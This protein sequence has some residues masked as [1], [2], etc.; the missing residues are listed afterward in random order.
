MT[1]NGFDIVPVD[2]ENSRQVGTVF[3]SVYG[4]DYPVKDVYRPD[5]LWR[6]VREGRLK[7]ALAFDTDG[8]PAGYVSLIKTAPNPRLWEAGSLVVDPAYRTTDLALILIR[9]FLQGP[10]AET[11]DAD[12]LFGEAVCHHYFSQMCSVKSGLIDCAIEL[13]QLDGSS[14]KDRSAQTARISCVFNF[15][16]LSSRPLTG[17]L[18]AEYGEIL[19][20]LAQPFL[21][22][23]FTDSREPLHPGVPS[24]WEEAYHAT[25]RTWKI[26]VRSAG[27]DWPARVEGFLGEAAR[28][29]VISLQITLDA[30]WPHVGAATEALRR[31]GFFLGGLAPRWFGSD[32]ILM[33]QVLGKE[34]DF[35]GILL[36]S[37]RAEELLSFVRA[38]RERARRLAGS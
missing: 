19:R 29:G 7:A 9:Y 6:E 8:R 37:R 26:S 15:L 33:Q 16:E 20:W 25:A 34:P 24:R 14:F 3:E 32:G 2:A 22:R 5:A 23:T 30:A 35:E 1:G 18:P 17:Y 13:D 10:V 4:G 11:L 36:Y 31:R 27:A 28:R 12:G 21:P 38:D